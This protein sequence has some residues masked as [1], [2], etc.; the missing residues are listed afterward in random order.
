M[1]T[2][3]D[4]QQIEILIL[5][6]KHGSFRQ[7]ARALNLSPP[8]LTSAINHLEEKLGVR[9]LNRS[10]R[11]LS[12]TAVGEEFLNNM[13]P[14]V[15]DYR[16]IVDSLN[17]HRLTPEGVVK[18]NLPRIVLDLFFQRY[19]IAFKTAYPDVTLELFTTDRKVNIIESGFDAGIRYSRDVPKDMIA[20]PFGEKL[21]LIPVA[22]PDY[23][24]QAGAPDTPQS[25]INFR[26]INRCFP[27]GEKYRWEFISP[28]G[29]P[30]EVAVKGDLV[31]DSDT[32]MIQAAESGLGIAFVYQSLVSAQLNAGSLIR[33]L[34]SYRYPA[35]HFCVYYP[36]RKHIPAPLRA[37]ITW[38]MAQNKSI[39][40]E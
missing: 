37:F 25:L 31:V 28:D 39:L 10:T 7:A 27:S 26:C 3:P 21:S 8:A 19:F 15:N 24:R 34:P 32:A 18:V 14:V 5:I 29:E 9:L 11:S 6:V 20:I 17:Y 23:I 35:D 12:L 22:S 1:K 38:V 2:L 40:H 4:L 13:T 30:G 16:R 33:L 36:S